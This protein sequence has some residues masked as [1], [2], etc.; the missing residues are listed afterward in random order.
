MNKYNLRNPNRRPVEERFAE[1]EAPCTKRA[2]KL[3]TTFVTGNNSNPCLSAY[4]PY[5]MNGI[6]SLLV[7]HFGKV[8]KGCKQLVCSLANVGAES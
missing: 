1:I 2:K 8:H 6:D 7:G 4:K 5:G 3:D